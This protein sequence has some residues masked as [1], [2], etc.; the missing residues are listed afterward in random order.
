M[1]S[2]KFLFFLL[3]LALVSLA[4]CQNQ[5]EGDSCEFLGCN[6]EKF[7]TCDKKDNICKCEDGMIVTIDDQSRN[8]TV[9]AGFACDKNPECIED[10]YCDESARPLPLCTCNEGHVSSSG[11]LEGVVCYKDYGTPCSP[12]ARLDFCNIQTLLTCSAQSS[13]CECM[14]EGLNFEWSPIHRRCVGLAG[15]EGGCGFSGGFCTPKATCETDMCICEEGYSVS[16]GKKC[17]LAYHSPCEIIGIETEKCNEMEQL[18]CS[19]SGVCLVNTGGNCDIGAEAEF[20]ECAQDGAQCIEGV[21]A[22]VKVTTDS[23]PATTPSGEPECN[24]ECDEDKFFECVDGRCQCADGMMLDA[25]GNCTVK[26]GFSCGQNPECIEDAFCDRSYFPFPLCQCNAGYL[27]SISP[28]EGLLC[29][30]SHGTECTNENPGLF[31]D[32]CHFQIQ[33]VCTEQGTCGCRNEGVDLEWNSAHN[34]CAGLVGGALGCGGISNLCTTKANCIGGSKCECADGYSASQGGKCQLAYGASCE[35]IGIETEK[36]NEKERLSC[37]SFGIC[38]VNTG[39]GCE[40]GKLCVNSKDACV[41]GVCTA[42]PD[43]PEETTMGEGEP[44]D[45]T[46]QGTTTTTTT[47]PT[48]TTTTTEAPCVGGSCGNGWRNQPFVLTVLV[49]HSVSILFI[50]SIV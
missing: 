15:V 32:Y 40:D 44:G 50:F 36:C 19:P 27:S 31:I 23:P 49:I 5:G 16:Q 22:E 25:H 48:T 47:K 34:R 38:L 46:T 29:Y 39:G 18:S 24:P 7:L 20:R 13:T 37:S 33:L 41:A 3:S 35:M 11:S 2:S 1:H 10:A 42:I 21:C 6:V 12:D 17:Q 43:P 9:K 45:T 8:C 4:N 26:V 30:K 14:E 28:M